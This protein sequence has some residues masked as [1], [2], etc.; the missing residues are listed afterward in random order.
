M[1]SVQSLVT[2]SSTPQ[3]QVPGTVLTVRQE[4]AGSIVTG[5]TIKSQVLGHPAHAVR[6]E[7]ANQTASKIRPVWI[8]ERIRLSSTVPQIRGPRA[9]WPAYRARVALA[10]GR[11]GVAVLRVLLHLA[12]SPHST[13]TLT[14]GEVEQHQPSES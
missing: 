5:S 13:H 10:A 7:P 11:V 6:V 2:V 8:V 9:R 14:R 12:V 1:A 4:S 3:S